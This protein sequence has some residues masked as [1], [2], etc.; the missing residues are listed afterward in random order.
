MTPIGRVGNGQH[1]VSVPLE[2]IADCDTS[3]CIP[4]S[5]SAI[6][7]SRDDV[8]PIGGVG[9]GRHPVSV[10]LGRIADYGTSLNIPDSNSAIVGS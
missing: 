1:T 9:N 10:P 3:F 5:N 2:R 6:V 4:D 7:G 8:A